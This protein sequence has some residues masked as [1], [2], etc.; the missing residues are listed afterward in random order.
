MGA[1]EGADLARPDVVR[2]S[3]ERSGTKA[4]AARVQSSGTTSSCEDLGCSDKR[5]RTCYLS[6]RLP[7]WDQPL[8]E[9]EVDDCAGERLWDSCG[10]WRPIP[11]AIIRLLGSVPG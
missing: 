2:R 6:W 1:Q 4:G 7:A 8:F 3:E 9:S 11:P 5:T 10:R